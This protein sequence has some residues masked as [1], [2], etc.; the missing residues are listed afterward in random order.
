MPKMVKKDEKTHFLWLF[1]ISGKFTGYSNFEDAWNG[2][3]PKYNELYDKGIDKLTK[4]LDALQGCN[5][6]DARVIGVFWIG[7]WSRYQ[8]VR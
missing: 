5:L 3:V 2:R 1:D 6:A 8:K 7:I 4:L